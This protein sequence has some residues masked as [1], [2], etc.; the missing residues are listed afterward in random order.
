MRW[1]NINIDALQSTQHILRRSNCYSDPRWGPPCRCRVTAMPG[2]SSRVYSVLDRIDYYC[3][4]IHPYADLT[5]DIQPTE[6]SGATASETGSFITFTLL[7]SVRVF[8]WMFLQSDQL[9]GDGAKPACSRAPCTA[10]GGSADCLFAGEE[11]TEYLISNFSIDR[12]AGL[13]IL[14]NRTCAMRI[15]TALYLCTPPGQLQPANAS[16]SVH[17]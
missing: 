15:S 6:T 16:C 4:S 13:F 14:M 7:H 12:V 3:P 10:T 1:N 2:L 11:S 17:P 9:V 5:R 8:F